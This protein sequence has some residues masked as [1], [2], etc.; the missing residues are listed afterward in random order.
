MHAPYSRYSLLFVMGFLLVSFFAF[1]RWQSGGIL[2]GGD[3]WEY[4]TYNPSLF[5]HHDLDNLKTSIAWRCFENKSSVV[6]TSGH[7]A[8][9]ELTYP[10]GGD[11]VVIKAPCGIAIL[12]APF[13]AMGH[14][15]ARLSGQSANGF[16]PP[17]L[18]AVHFSVIFYVL[19]GLYYLRRTLR[20]F[21][22]EWVTALTML[23][24]VPGTNLLYFCVETS[25]MA[26]P[27]LFFLCSIILYSTVQFY[28]IAYWKY[29]LAIG[30]AGGLTAIS[31]PNDLLFMLIPVLF[32]ITGVDSIKGR[33][34]F[35][36]DNY[37]KIAASIFMF[38][39]AVFPQMLYWKTMS[40]HWVYYSYGNETFDF[41][42][43]HILKGMLGFKNG[44]LPY[45]PIMLLAIAGIPL[46]YIRRT[47]FFLL[48]VVF[49]T[50]H[51]YVIYSW[52]CWTY[53]NGMGSRPMIETYPLLAIPM[54][55]SFDFITRKALTRLATT[56]VVL[57][58]IIQQVFM[59]YQAS[60][61]MLWTEVSNKTFYFHTMFKTRMD[62]DDL[63][64]FDVAEKQPA[65]T[66][67]KNSIYFETF[68]DSTAPFQQYNSVSNNGYSF[69][70]DDRI[71]QFNF[72][73][74]TLGKC[75]LAPGDWLKVSFD[76]CSPVSN[77]NLYDCATINVRLKRD[78]ATIKLA[79]M[80]IQ[81]K[82][83][84]KPPYG[85]WRFESPVCGHEYM[86]IRIPADAQLSDSVIVFGYNSASS[87]VLINNMR[88]ASCLEVK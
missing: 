58:A 18:I 10:N 77:T 83:P 60:I 3:S 21:Y 22:S 1:H 41:S 39:V 85:I 59:C 50:I 40:G 27:Y 48:T 17:Y 30:L 9:P 55:L 61:N 71:L 73:N 72:L 5:I 14:L 26:H 75:A 38:F 8:G 79:P 68:N 25:P 23:A 69:A 88:I 52:W 63:I 7:I 44:W 67:L 64:M 28:K 36:K 31:R 70:L 2:Y 62:A 42:H 81:N 20:Q 19:L 49:I 54:A 82:I 35:W 57:F 32:G 34:H 11:K 24:V 51:I 80:R 74:T 16:S 84:N 29:A 47:G 56:A 45:A 46:L 15:A 65:K 6:D 43:P 87:T 76:V 53:I 37:L 33:F 66:I 12:Q 13:F 86:H 4:Y 78:T